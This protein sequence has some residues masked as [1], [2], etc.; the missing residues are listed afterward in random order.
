MSYMSYTRKAWEVIG[1]TLH[2]EAY[3]PT[4]REGSDA[5]AYGAPV[6]ASDEWE[7]MPCNWCGEEVR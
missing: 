6:F 5:L 2:G 1:Y 7:A 4:C 3:C